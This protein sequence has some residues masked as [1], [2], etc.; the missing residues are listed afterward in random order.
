AHK[1]VR[2]VTGTRDKQKAENQVLKCESQR[3]AAQE[4]VRLEPRGLSLHTHMGKETRPPWIHVNQELEQGHSKG[5]AIRRDV[6]ECAHRNRKTTGWFCVC[7][8]VV[9]L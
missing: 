9:V 8:P 2:D 5:Y 6:N 1:E 3:A 4:S 7:L